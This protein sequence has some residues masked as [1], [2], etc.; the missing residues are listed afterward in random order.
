MNG[1]CNIQYCENLF[2]YLI[3]KYD[4]VVF[5]YLVH[6]HDFSPQATVN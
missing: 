2:F 5:T 6:L 1:K 4:A 3:S